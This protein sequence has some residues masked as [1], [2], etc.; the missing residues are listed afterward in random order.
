MAHD[1]F[2]LSDIFDRFSDSVFLIDG[3]DILYSNPAAQAAFPD[4]GAAIPPAFFEP[5][6]ALGYEG[7]VSLPQGV[8]LVSSSALDRNT[9]LILRPSSPGAEPYLVSSNL[10]AQLRHTLNSLSVSIEQLR[11]EQASPLGAKLL[12]VQSQILHRLLRLTRQLE[13]SQEDALQ[14]HPLHTINFTAL[15]QKLSQTLQDYLTEGEPLFRPS[16]ITQPLFISGNHDYLEQLLLSLLSNGIKSCG[17]GGTFGLR[18]QEKNQRAVVSVWD[19]GEGISP[20]RMGQLFA[21]KH[22]GTLPRPHDGSGLDLWIA[23][24][25]ALMHGGVIVA[26]NRPEGGAEFTVSFPLALGERPSFHSR[27]PLPPMED[28]S[29]LLIALS[30]VLPAQIY[31]S[32]W[33]T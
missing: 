32:I 8:F 4:F 22:R 12:P 3:P 25:I 9:L 16:L 24:R 33:G 18:L 20:A 7:C 19:N 11:A 5:L 14:G 1:R 15:C 27:G 30:D 31:G 2:P 17:P 21:P 29:P 23:H 26:G 6:Q 10:P 13:L 28:F